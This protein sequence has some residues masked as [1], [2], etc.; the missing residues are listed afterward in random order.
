MLTTSVRYEIPTTPLYML[1]ATLS[2]G[3]VARGAAGLGELSATARTARRA[4]AAQRRS[5]VAWPK[6][7]W[8]RCVCCGRSAGAAPEVHNLHDVS[9]K[10]KTKFSKSSSNA[11]DKSTRGRQSGDL[12]DTQHRSVLPGRQVLSAGALCDVGPSEAPAR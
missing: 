6:G 1:K 4:A 5:H 12:Q 7:W 3:R 10:Q 9:G 2:K 11:F 8:R